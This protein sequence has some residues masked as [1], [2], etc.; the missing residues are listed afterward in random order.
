QGFASEI[1]TGP[2][3]AAP[4]GGCRCDAFP[5]MLDGAWSTTRVPAWQHRAPGEVA[6]DFLQLL[7]GKAAGPDDRGRPGDQDG[8]PPLLAVAVAAAKPVWAGAGAHAGPSVGT[9]LRD[10]LTTLGYPP[11]RLVA[12][13]V[14]ALLYLRRS[15]PGLASATRV[16]VCDVGAG[17]L[18]L[19]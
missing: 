9:E 5:L 7:L 1:P 19:S 15:H 3:G 12:A 14:A 11:Q 18:G 16:V 8:P 13:P 17:S 6:Q 2:S 10:I 4:A